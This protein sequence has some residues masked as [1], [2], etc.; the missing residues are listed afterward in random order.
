MGPIGRDSYKITKVDADW[1]GGDCHSHKT[2]LRAEL[3]V[4]FAA[5]LLQ[6]SE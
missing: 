5:G 2:G 3:A 6:L 4:V 1:A